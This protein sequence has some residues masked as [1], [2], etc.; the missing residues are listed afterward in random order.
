MQSKSTHYQKSDVDQKSSLDVI[1]ETYQSKEGTS[2]KNH[3]GTVRC[4][5]LSSE[6]SNL[7]L[8]R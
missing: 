1:S 5:V 6:H 4:S 3:S 7:I 8:S 2:S